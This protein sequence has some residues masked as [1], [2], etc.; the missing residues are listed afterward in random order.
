MA[1]KT[2]RNAHGGGTIRQRTDGRWEARY[3]LGIN[4]GTGKQIQKSIYGKTQKEVRQKLQKIC[5]E[6][7][8]GT[9]SEPQ[10]MTLDQWLT[11]WEKE[12]IGN[13][14]ANTVKSYSDHIR[15]HIKPALGACKLSD[16]VPHMIQTFYNS[17]QRDDGLSPKTVKNVHGVFH[18]ALEQAMKIGYIRSNPAEACTLPHIVKKE[19]SPLDDSELAAF[20]R[21]IQGNPYE[22]VYFVAVFTGMRQGELLGLTWNCVDFEK[23]T[24]YVCKQHQKQKGGK[25]YVFSTLKNDKPRLLDVS[26]AVMDALC[27]QRTR[28]SDWVAQAGP[29]WENRDNFVFTTEFGRYLC[30]QTVYLDF[31]KVVKRL[32]LASARFHDMRHTYAVIS[33]KA[34]D[35]IKTVQENMGHHTAAFTLDTYAHV[36]PGMKRDSA[37]RLDQ[38]ILGVS[39]L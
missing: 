38:Y 6:I 24:I 26:E 34:G 9:Y 7:D 12:Y 29:A 8:D 13:V 36:T 14:K 11:V 28:Q 16:L 10:K 4:P 31:K 22:L 19:I 1:Q 25:D 39:K 18:R 3:T 21:A 5:T 30:N 15:L 35:D 37:K 23:H 27:R 20:L 2:T 33:L 32:G 17:L